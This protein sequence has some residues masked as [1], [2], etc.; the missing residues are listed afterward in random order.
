MMWHVCTTTHP[1]Q[2]QTLSGYLTCAKQSFDYNM[3]IARLGKRGALSGWKKSVLLHITA[4]KRAFFCQVCSPTIPSPGKFNIK[5]NLWKLY[6][7]NLWKLKI[8]SHHLIIFPVVPRFPAFGDTVGIESLHV[9]LACRSHWC[10]GC[11]DT[12]GLG[13][14]ITQ[15]LLSWVA[16][17]KFVKTTLLPTSGGYHFRSFYIDCL[18]LRGISTWSFH[19]IKQAKS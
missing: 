18:G 10:G 3:K 14:Q 11:G 15:P 19:H 13:W 8:T 12:A 2:E 5:W 16:C 7:S 4:I 9:C 17:T 1:P 6:R